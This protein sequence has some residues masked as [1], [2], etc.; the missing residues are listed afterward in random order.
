MSA[1]VTRPATAAST[2]PL[3][4]LPGLAACVAVAAAAFA[5]QW[6]EVA[7][8]GHTW[9]EA[10]VLAILLGTTVRAVW[11]PRSRWLPGIS[12]A[13]K[14]LLEVA[15]VL[16]GATVSAGAI[17]RAG[18]FLLAGIAGIVAVAIV[19][20]Y[21]LGRALG[22]GHR[23]A[24]LIACGNAICGNSAIAAVAPV[25]GADGEEVA[26][27]IAFTAVLGVVVVLGLPLLAPLLR[28]GAVQYGILAGLTVYAVPQVL[29]AAAPLGAAAV[30]TGTLVKLVRVLMLGPVV[31]ALSLLT[32]RLRDAPDEAAPHLTAGDRPRVGRPPL[33][34][35]V[36]WFIVGFL[37][38][39]AAR[40]AGGVPDSVVPA[41]GTVAILLTVVSM[42]ALGLMTDVRVVA[43]AGG[44]V[45]TTVALS[46]AGLGALSLGLIHLLA[47]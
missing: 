43:R 22:L 16:L 46:L 37:A 31:L 25:I 39:A 41:L 20:S 45:V 33:H 7:V 19:G 12:F 14:L 34:Q 38:L 30:Q 26:S 27:S 32:R 21:A 10:L 23:L 35:L 29:A 4:L 6:A 40:S 28:L 8:F 44:R 42:S 17:L 18:P 1:S 3:G 13:A 2:R 24:L 47:A 9:I 36:P 5:V 15:V 11:M